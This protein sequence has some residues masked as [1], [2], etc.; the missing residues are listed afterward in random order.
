MRELGQSHPIRW[1]R[2]TLGIRALDVA[3]VVVVKREQITAQLSDK[4]HKVAK[5]SKGERTYEVAVGVAEWRE[6]GRHCFLCCQV[7]SELM[8][9]RPSVAGPVYLII[10]ISLL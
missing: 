6:D 9:D 4:G 5:R 1:S 2:R 7:K 10:Y 3:V 8:F